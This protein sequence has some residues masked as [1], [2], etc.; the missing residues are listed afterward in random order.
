MA[1]GQPYPPCLWLQNVSFP[2][3]HFSAV[4]IVSKDLQVPDKLITTL[5][6]YVPALIKHRL[7]ADPTP[8]D[9]PQSHHFPTAVLYADISG[10]T[11]LT[12]RL[13]HH[14]PAGAEELTSL[15]N[16]YFGRLIRRITDHGGDVVKFAGDALIA[17]WPAPSD[18][19]LRQAVHRAAQCGLAVQEQLNNFDAGAGIRLSL[20]L[21]LGAGDMLTMHLGGVYNRWEFLVAGWPLVQVGDVSHLAA[22]GEI[23]LT[24][25]A[26]DFIRDVAAGEKI[27]RH[28]TTGIRL[29]RLTTSIP[30]VPLALPSLSKNTADGLKTYIPGAILARLAAGQRGWLAELRR[31]T[32][33]FVNLSALDYGM[34]LEQAQTVMRTLQTAIYRYEGSINKLSV[35]DKGV[36]L[37]AGFG[38]PPLAHEDDAIRGV[39][40]ALDMHSELRAL[41]L[42]GA[43]GITTGRAFCGAV[44]NDLRREYTMIGDVVNLSARLMQAADGTILCD[45]A[46]YRA[47][48]NSAALEL[49]LGV[50]LDGSGAVGDVP[51]FEELSPILVKGKSAPVPVYRPRNQGRMTV[52]PHM[53]PTPLVGRLAEQALLTEKLQRLHRER[54]S[55]VLLIEGEAGM[56]KSLLVSELLQQA[57]VLAVTTLVGAGS[58]IEKSTPYHAWRPVFKQFFK[59]DDMPDDLPARR[60]AVLKKV[61]QLCTGQSLPG[62][63]ATAVELTPLLNSVLPLD[64]PDNELTAQ[65]SGKVRA[66]NT[67]NLLVCI[68]RQVV[69][70]RGAVEPPILLVLEDARWLDSASWGLARLVAEQVPSL[71]MVLAVR[72]LLAPVPD[73]YTQL[74][75]LPRARK[76]PLGQLA[77]ED[78]SALISQRLGV[79]HL[80]AALSQLVYDKA[81]GNP[82]FTEELVYALRDSGLITVSDSRCTL[83]PEAGNP[84]SLRLPDTIQGVITSRI[85][86]LTPS[87][88]LTLKVASVIGR[89]FEYVT[90]HDIHPIELEKPHLSDY[91]NTLDKMDITQIDQPEPSLAYI[92]RQT[93]IQEVAYNMMLF[94]QRRELH[95]AVARWYEKTYTEDLSPHYSVLAY[96]WRR[97]NVIPK[98]TEYLE[99]AGDEALKTFANE[100]ATEFFSHALQLVEPQPGNESVAPPDDNLLRQ[101]ARWEMKLGQAYVNWV[102]F[103]D[104]QAH[105][106]RGLGLLGYPVPRGRLKLIFGL[107]W[108]AARQLV[109]WLLPKLSVRK[110]VD[111][112][113]LKEASQAYDGLTA[114]YYFAGE[115]LLSLYA[116]FRSLNLAEKLGPSP[117]LARGSTAVGAIMGFVPAHRVAQTYCYRAVNMTRKFDDVPA[118]MW[119]WLGTGM[120]YAGVGNWSRA[121]HLFEQVIESAERLGDRYRWDD[122]VGNLAV[123]KYFQGDLATSMQLWQDVLASARRRSDAHNQA[124]ALRGVVYGLLPQGKFDEAF[125][126]LENL[127]R[128]LAQDAHIIDEALRID[129]HGLL[130]WVQT[131]RHNLPA[132][133]ESTDA[134]FTLIANNMPTS[135]LSLPGYAALAEMH[136]NRWEAEVVAGSGIQIYQLP[137]TATVRR[138]RS[139]LTRPAQRACGALKKYARVFPVGRARANLLQGRFEWLS[140]RP[141][142]AREL[143]G[144]GLDAACQLSMPFEEALI[145]FEMGRHLPP[146]HPE[147]AEHLRR[148]AATFEQLGADFHYQHV[149]EAIACKT[150]P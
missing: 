86:R 66:D 43:I 21:A 115:T 15:L 84:Q 95:Q 99:K 106:E 78:V 60:A 126:A 123:V 10:F 71:M 9:I 103:G 87:Q 58:A 127:Q 147:R 134:A 53:L 72:P 26:W 108:E 102:R 4:Q 97:A 1:L 98:A 20:R 94:A 135:Y 61:Q 12:E 91:L 29:H 125:S 38:L 35:D 139:K 28:N 55:S 141:R 54:E 145:R 80:P 110:N 63:S 19:H 113:A 111:R 59:L 146:E 137:E 32:V 16:T 88:Q 129:L 120:Y 68:L 128:L 36:T 25:P 76:I 18:E 144:I 150:H 3:G 107:G 74:L 79:A 65:M 50:D 42:H 143:W 136:L 22:P 56:G 62:G 37:I 5:A 109:W 119:V 89:A 11:A 122:G 64:W 13:A 124:W 140:N 6:S 2:G 132:A 101:R 47:T 41:G 142:L 67:H 138:I 73:D 149:K 17:L 90:L 33:L 121:T 49:L 70:R 69:T 85:D 40:A 23:T 34:P 112:T 51:F 118:K 130:A 81:E 104:G 100:E 133:N 30:T 45:A 75:A 57:R 8:I 48:Q 83:A 52:D 14:G 117:E 114:V 116:A 92:F 39:Q 46:T 31:I 27:T 77:Q 44:G 131:V 148:A 7:A 82:F 24:P 105:L 93:I 96:H